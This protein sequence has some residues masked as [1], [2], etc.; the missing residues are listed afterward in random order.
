MESMENL[1]TELKNLKKRKHI[2]VQSHNKIT[3]QSAVFDTSLGIP[4][5]RILGP[6]WKCLSYL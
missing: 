5:G 4:Q 2:L 1:R 6:M 3:V